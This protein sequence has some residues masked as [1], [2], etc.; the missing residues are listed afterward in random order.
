MASSMSW[1]AERKV[2]APLRCSV[3]LSRN[4]HSTE[5]HGRP[6]LRA[7]ATSTSESPT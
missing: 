2:V 6:A 3:S 1:G 5:M 7:V 4:P